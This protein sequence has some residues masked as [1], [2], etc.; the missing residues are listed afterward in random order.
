MKEK[1]DE[2]ANGIF[3]N[4]PAEL[5]LTPP[6]LKL[7]T[8][9]GGQC[10]GSFVA[11]NSKNRQMKGIVCTSSHYIRLEQVS[12]QGETATI[13]FY[14]DGT[15]FMPGEV[16]KGTILVI[17]DCGTARVRFT[18]NV[19]VPSCTVSSGKIKDLFHFTNLARENSTEAVQLFRNKHFEEVFLYRDNS[20]IALYRGLI[21]STSKGLAMEEF[22][23]AIHKKLPIMLTVNQTSFEYKNCH[24]KFTDEIIITKD[25]WGFGEFHIN[26]DADFI[27]PEHKIIWADNFIGRTF[28]LSFMADPSKMASGNNYARIK[29]TS[30]RQTI[31]IEITAIKPGIRHEVVIKQL[32][33]QKKYYNL[34][35]LYLDFSMDRI[36]TEEYISSVEKIVAGVPSMDLDIEAEL[37]KIHLGIIGMQEDVIESGFERLAPLVKEIYRQDTRLYCAY[38]YL[39]GLW[40]SNSHERDECIK[41]IRKCYEEKEYS[42]QV[43]W[44]LFYLDREYEPDRV[45]LES[46]YGHIKAGC[47]SP[48]LYLEVCNILNDTPDKLAELNMEV[49]LCLHWGC[50]ND[51]LEK[52]L[53]LRYTYL[54]SRLKSYSKL[55]LSDLC[56]FYEKYN[57]DEILVA[58]CSTFM[59]GQMTSPEAFKWYA[60]GIDKNLKLTDLYEY[61]MYSLDETQEIHLKQ[62][63]LLYFLYDNHLTASK[64]AMLYA[65][66]IKN[67]EQ[68]PDTYNAYMNNIE[69]FCFAQLHQGRISKNLAIIYEECIN[70]DKITDN[71]AAELPKVMFSHEILCNN[72]DITGVYVRHRELKE[73]EF[74]PLVHGRAVVH[75]FTEQS[76]VFLADGLDNR[77]IMSI[78]Y[79]ANKLLNLDHLASRCFERNKRDTGLLLYLY[80]RADH[81]HQTGTSAMEVHRAVINIQGLSDYQHRKVFVALVKYYFD[82]FEGQ[83]L[84]ECLA[85]MDWDDVSS[86]ERAQF[87]EYCAV[88]HCYGKAMEGI[89]KYGYDKIPGKR[90]LQI[91]SHT[92]EES[93]DTENVYLVRLAWHIFNTGKFD[94]NVLKYLCRYFIDGIY[95][96]T[97]VWQAA[98]GFGIECKDFEE[99]IIAQMV[100]T[101]EI[102]P[103]AYNIFYSYYE[104]GDNK[105]LV[106]AFLKVIAY[107]YLIKNWLIPNDMFKYFYNEVRTQENMICLIAVLKYLSQKKKLTEEETSFADYNVNMLYEKNIVFSFFKDFIGKFSLPIHI[108]DAQYVEYIA[109]PGCEVKIHYLISQGQKIQSSDSGEEFI[110]ETMRDVFEGIRVKEFVLF[111]DELLQYYIS[112]TDGNGERITRSV[113]VHF[114]ESMDDAREGSRY[115]TLNTMMIAKEMHDD[116]TLID[117][118]E[119]Y[120][121][122]RENVKR[123]FKPILD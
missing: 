117:L 16:A 32:A 1:I 105:R 22:L 35:K 45:K 112:E 25:N 73:E 75:I 29:I 23:I 90:L 30:V 51:Y 93:A 53:V 37:Y 34:T 74:V 9:S 94:E 114:D 59:K 116:A 7:E 81:L 10:A 72:P 20:N 6:S 80:D 8:D 36:D 17:T 101:E 118:M 108:M 39:K 103:E 13:Q 14:F 109:E 3:K 40:A 18:V 63:V 121:R 56:K 83:L 52:E 89:L 68:I 71:V 33:L 85:S 44:F 99:R 106:K 84:D 119:E 97:K 28:K 111:Q 41:K 50:I 91:S 31:E 26:S 67:K 69:E 86:S 122:E 65:Y 12:F 15:N 95:E 82:N 24:E 107:K 70:E 21:S 11:S 113:S 79:T 110:T 60:M 57:D 19:N 43:L 115:H 92:F 96:E 64:K 5:V 46:I 77:Y 78:D 47:H 120:A 100:F 4:G 62:S 88:R 98:R 123:L 38:L 49:V 54:A 27:I 66:I 48:V 102:S 58:I 76:H 55:V 104:G 42:W 87:I 61:Y 2:A